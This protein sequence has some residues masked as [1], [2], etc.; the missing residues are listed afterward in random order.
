MNIRLY[1]DHFQ[2]PRYGSDIWLAKVLIVDQDSIQVYY[3]EDIE[4]FN[5]YYIN[6]CLKTS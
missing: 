4:L 5:K 3:Y 1:L 6:I 2:Y